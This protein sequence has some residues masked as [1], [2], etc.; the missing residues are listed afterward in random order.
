MRASLLGS[1]KNTAARV[2]DVS[3][4]KAGTAMPEAEWRCCIDWRQSNVQT[5][6]PLCGRGVG[7][8]RRCLTRH[9]SRSGWARI[10]HTLCQPATMEFLCVWRSS[11]CVLA[12]RKLNQLALAALLQQLGI[13]FHDATGRPLVKPQRRVLST[14]L[15][16]AVAYDWFSPDGSEYK[17]AD[18]SERRTL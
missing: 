6:Y 14:F 15:S 16:V 7:G 17:L 1:N 8:S 18:G 9:A 3:V 4:S 11:A 13:V 10:S 5:H 12:G 2:L